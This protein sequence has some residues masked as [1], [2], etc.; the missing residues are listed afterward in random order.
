M[1]EHDKTRRAAE[2]VDAL[3][4][5]YVHLAVFVIV[6]ALLVLINWMASPGDWW[7]QWPLL[8]W[9]IGVAAHGL[10]VLG[11]RRR[12]PVLR[13]RLRKIRQVRERM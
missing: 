7:V 9:G 10:A 5:F 4:G 13:W 1:T 2:H 6:N 11:Q 12:G 3:M 8:G